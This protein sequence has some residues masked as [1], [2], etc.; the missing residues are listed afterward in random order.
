MTALESLEKIYED[1]LR[2]MELSRKADSGFRSVTIALLLGY[3]GQD[4]INQRFA[5][6]AENALRAVDPQSDDRRAVAAYV[7]DK[8]V[9]YKNDVNLGMMFTAMY[10]FLPPL[11]IGETLEYRREL[12]A[13]FDK[14]FSP[15]LRTPVM[16]RFRK[17]LDGINGAD[18]KASAN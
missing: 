16:V 13:R 5:A 7:F 15:R 2:D 4:A 18:L 12:A 6:D 14:E 9:A 3:H 11:I 17:A 10:Q 1:Y 8:G